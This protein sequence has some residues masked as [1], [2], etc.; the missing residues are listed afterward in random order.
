MKILHA[1]FTDGFAGSERY[2]ADLARL[3]IDLGHDVT[4][5]LRPQRRAPNINDWLDGRL[6]IVEV[7]RFL[8]QR[9]IKSIIRDGQFDLVHAHLGK[10][11][12]AFCKCQI[13]TVATLHLR[14]KPKP[15]RAYDGLM[16]IAGWQAKH[17]D[18][19]SG[20]VEVISNWLPSLPPVDQF[21]VKALR[22]YLG[23]A[24]ET[25]IFGSAGRLCHSKGPDLLIEAYKAA[26][27]AN[28]RL[29]LVGEGEERA[30]LEKLASSDKSISFLAARKD[31][32]NIYASI[33]VFVSSARFEPF[34]LSILEAMDAGCSI[35]S[36]ITEGPSEFLPDTATLIDPENIEQLTEVIRKAALT[37]RA[38]RVYDMSSFQGPNKARLIVSFYETVIAEKKHCNPGHL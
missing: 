12:R 8:Q 29:I 24:D 36:T 35:I 20:Q 14:Y 17:L 18:D 28:T 23:A 11:A 37:E 2:C 19:F 38:R 21:A 5:A 4:V 3:Q 27:T 34:G 25:V 13:P 16:C 32:E 6:N 15:Y 7:D 1:I 33:D 9:K 22:S 31:V 10:A 26:Q 30:R